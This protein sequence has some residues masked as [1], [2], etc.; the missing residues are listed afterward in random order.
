MS[1]EVERAEYS[2]YGKVSKSDTPEQGDF[3]FQ[4][5]IVHPKIAEIKEDE[6]SDFDAEEYDVI[7]LSQSCDLLYE[8]INL[9]LVC[10]FYTLTE[11]ESIDPNYRS[12]GKKNALRNGFI[13]GM[14]L[15]DKCNINGIND[16]L[17]VD[18][19]NTCSIPLDLLKEI[20]TNRGDR[21]RLL[22]PYRERMSQAFAL[23]FMRVGLP[24]DIPPFK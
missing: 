8:K 10:P 14:H 24:I 7:I 5:Q 20:I 18:F 15:L 6:E 9:A 23:F 1:A 22:P 3:I 13:I 4:C 16:Y 19:K 12:I 2:W 21:I 11:L 17:V